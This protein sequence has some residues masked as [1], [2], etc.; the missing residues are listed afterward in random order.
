VR[1]ADPQARRRARLRGISGEDRVAELLADEG[2][3][4]RDRNWIGGGGELD[5]IVCRDGCWRM[6]EVKT[7]DPEDLDGLEA[8]DARKQRKLRS[9]AEAYLA[10]LNE[11]VVEV[12]FLVALVEGAT[13][14]LY[15]DAF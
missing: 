12:A 2:W 3:L 5:L 4:L 14:R 13:I 6:V 8:I 7:R 10:A 9:A 15:D 11:P 1:G